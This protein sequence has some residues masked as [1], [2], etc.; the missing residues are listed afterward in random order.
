MREYIA[1]LETHLA[2]AHRQAVRL[3]KRQATL[4]S[5]L[6]EFGTAMIALGKC[7]TSAVVPLATLIGSRGRQA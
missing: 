4:G 2:E 6:A 1:A 3:V 7:V 5:S